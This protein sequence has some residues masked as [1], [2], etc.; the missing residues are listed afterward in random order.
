MGGSGGQASNSENGIGAGGR[1]R[2]QGRVVEWGG[3]SVG[4][5][6]KV[7]RKWISFHG[8]N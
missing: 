8:E 1:G 4:V 6:R 7:G 5:R 2:E 3:N